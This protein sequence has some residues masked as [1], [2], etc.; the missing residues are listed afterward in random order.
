[1]DFA[2]Y[3]ERARSTAIYPNK[4]NNMVYPTLGLCGESGEIAEKLKKLMRDKDGVADD[5]WRRSMAHE[6]GDV[7][8][9][10]TAI[11]NEIG[12]SLEEIAELN[13]LKLASRKDRN[14]LHGSGDNR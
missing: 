12:H 9:Y 2:A 14:M 3:E 1:M 8:W 10:I 4:G 13:I 11:A 5:E 7:L 6:L